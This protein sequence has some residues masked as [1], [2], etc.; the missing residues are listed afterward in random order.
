MNAK[1]VFSLL[2]GLT[3]F[4]LYCVA[5]IQPEMVGSTLINEKPY[6]Y[7][8][9]LSSEQQFGSASLV[10]DGVILTDAHVIY[11]DT[12]H[13]WIPAGDFG[14]Y[15]RH[16][17]AT[18]TGPKG[19]GFPP[20]GFYKWDSYSTRVQK[21]LGD[22]YNF[23]DVVDP[24]NLDFAAGWF[25]G[26]VND[27]LIK[28]FAEVDVSDAGT[29]SAI[30]EEREQMLV[31]YP[32]AFGATGPMY[33]TPVG[34][35]FFWWEGIEEI[36][37]TDSD[38]YWLSLYG[39]DDIVSSGGNSG[40]PLYL[41]DD[42]GGWVL[43]GI[44]LGEIDDPYSEDNYTQVRSV[45]DR[46]WELIELAAN[47]RG[48]S[49][50]KRVKDVQVSEE[51]TDSLTIEWTDNSTGEA[52]YMVYRLT[53]D[54]WEEV[55]S[56]PAGANSYKD[57]A[58][59]PGHVYQYA[60]HSFSSSGNKMPKSKAIRGL[61][62]G[63]N[64]VAATALGEPWLSFWNEGFA[65]W[66]VDETDSLRAGE[67]SNNAYSDLHLDIIGPGVLTLSTTISSEVNPDYADPNS[68]NE[69]EVYDA[70]WV[71]I[72]GEPASFSG[73]PFFL[74]GIFGPLTLPLEVPEGSHRITF[75]FDKDGYASEGEDTAYLHSLAWQPDPT[76]GHPVYG[77]YSTGWAGWDFA[78]WLGLYATKA[79]SWLGHSE[80][81]W[82]K[83]VQ[84]E[85]DGAVYGYSMIPEIGFFYTGPGTYPY[86][87][88]F[89]SGTWVEYSPGTGNFGNGAQFTQL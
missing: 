61:T 86:L 49:G 72:D 7:N 6:S 68:I 89:S 26:S 23:F 20:A 21:P 62:S 79:D 5:Q 33:A 58:V 2:A 1:H 13:Q 52:G 39:T 77:G 55:A 25:A 28:D 46:G 10:H 24:S 34:N 47:A 56:L 37:E 14:F 73:Q 31:G 60:V 8:G 57:L 12:V 67:I 54:Y 83:V 78:E 15:P 75:S 27:A 50:L 53:N 43:G 51:A 35:Y 70:L 40:G 59:E 36:I 3:A 85:N 69:G 65:N 29:L 45:D 66:H 64:A 88:K 19:Q 84:S 38:E 9:M 44:L 4:S 17:A 42:L 63:S 30:R 87:Y 41:K 80:L 48:V 22:E 32:S 11:D 74:S 81:G 18:T 82:M 76:S 71:L 16:N